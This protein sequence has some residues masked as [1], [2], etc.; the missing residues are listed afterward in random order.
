M[1]QPAGPARPGLLPGR[2]LLLL[3]AIDALAA[4]V[5]AV[6]WPAGLFAL[7]QTAPAHDSLLCWRGLGALTLGHVP[8]LALGAARPA[9]SSGLV[10]VPLFGRALE[11]GVWL[12]LLGSA[13]LPLP[14]RPLGL[15]LAHDLFWLAVLAGVLFAWRGERRASNPASGGRQ[16]PVEREPTGG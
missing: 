9:V 4:G 12:W 5:W 8:C 10:L 1:E 2:A 13:S 3:A 7:L 15:L 16:P 6:W 11:A 14:G